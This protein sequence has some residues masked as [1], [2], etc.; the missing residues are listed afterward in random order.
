MLYFF[1]L[2]HQSDFDVVWPRG[3]ISKTIL[4][5]W[6][7]RLKELGASI[8]TSTR[9]IDVVVKE[10]HV[11]QIVTKNNLGLE[12]NHDVDA[13]VFAVG[14]SGMQSVLRTST[15]LGARPEFRNTNN[16][17]SIDVMAVR[18]Y[19]DR[20]IQIEFA[21][22]ACF[23]FQETTGWT[24]FNLNAIHD[25]FRDSNTTVIEANFY[26]S[27][28]MMPMADEDV[29]EDVM[30][31]LRVAEPSAFK[32]VVVEDFVVVR[33]PR[34]VTRKLLDLIDMRLDGLII[35]YTALTASHFLSS[36]LFS[37]TFYRALTSTS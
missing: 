12:Q 10:D 16:L 19:F 9:L 36:S 15:T 25:E 33:V 26:H 32:R 17:S 35:S 5:P 13:V 7:E 11:T 31:M 1:I 21:S 28:Q 18:I 27:N 30:K 6:S 29:L 2:A 4:A 37:Q 23:G 20:K 34:G 22:N 8:W 24:Y 3:T 14:I